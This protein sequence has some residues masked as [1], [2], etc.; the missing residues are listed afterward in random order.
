MRFL[1]SYLGF[2]DFVC[3]R[4]AQRE[5]CRFTQGL[6]P[7]TFLFTIALNSASF[8]LQYPFFLT[9]ADGFHNLK[10]PLVT[11][12]SHNILTPV[13]VSLESP[14]NFTFYFRISLNDTVFLKTYSCGKVNPYMLLL[15]TIKWKQWELNPHINCIHRFC[16][17]PWTLSHLAWPP[18]PCFQNDR[19]PSN[20]LCEIL[21]IAVATHFSSISTNLQKCDTEDFHL[22]HVLI[23]PIGITSGI[24]PWLHDMEFLR[25]TLRTIFT[26]YPLDGVETVGVEPTT[27]GC[28]INIS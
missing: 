11:F 9:M 10:T 26:S 5:S 28:F 3:P 23:C 8:Y 18:R 7:A 19:I 13:S 12:C 15:G 21:A 25:C 17:Y 2:K 24:E 20:G 27:A 14:T 4:T 22:P 16:T 6:M 1:L